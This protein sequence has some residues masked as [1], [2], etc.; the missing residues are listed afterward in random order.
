MKSTVKLLSALAL[1]VIL[2]ASCNKDPYGTYTY[3]SMY[4]ST[5][6]IADSLHRVEIIDHC[7]S[8]E[9][10]TRDH[11]YEGTYSTCFTKAVDEFYEAI[12]RISD[13]YIESRLGPGEDFAVFCV[14][15][16]SGG[17]IAFKRWV[18]DR[19]EE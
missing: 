15:A 8:F 14:N 4:V 5:S 2:F 7:R 19:L 9:Y 16:E 6:G 11:K 12:T 3:G 18:D 13:D 17:Y 1:A 10:F